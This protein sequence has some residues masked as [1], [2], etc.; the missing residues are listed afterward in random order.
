MSRQEWQPHNRPTNLRDLMILIALA[1]MPLAL[2]ASTYRHQKDVVVRALVM[3][4]SLG[5]PFGVAVVWFACRMFRSRDQ[6]VHDNLFLVVY[7]VLTFVSV[8]C[9]VFVFM[10][11]KPTAGLL[12]VSLFCLLAY[13]S[14]WI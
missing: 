10:F 2:A 11:D 6:R 13:L 12:G 7:M 9:I 1:G 8:L 5:V 14:S 3:I 4:A